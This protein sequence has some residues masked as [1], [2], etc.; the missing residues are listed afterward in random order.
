[1]AIRTRKDSGD[2]TVITST[3]HIHN[4]WWESVTIFLQETC[5]VIFNLRKSTHSQLFFLLVIL[6]AG[7]HYLD[8]SGRGLG[9]FEVWA[10]ALIISARP[11]ADLSPTCVVQDLILSRPFSQ[12]KKRLWQSAINESQHVDYPLLVTE[13]PW[14]L[15]VIF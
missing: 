11:L 9:R 6:R 1:M 7:L 4:T 10:L 15:R 3:Q 2:Q 5:S 13:F 14:L 12:A 8:E